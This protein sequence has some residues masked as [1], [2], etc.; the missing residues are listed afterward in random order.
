MLPLPL[1][2][3]TTQRLRIPENGPHPLGGHLAVQT[4]FLKI[5]MPTAFWRARKDPRV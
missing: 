3:L 1:S 2:D 4:L 5:F